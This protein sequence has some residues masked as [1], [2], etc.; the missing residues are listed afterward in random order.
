MPTRPIFE[1]GRRR[2]GKQPSQA[3]VL[4][5]RGIG[6]VCQEGNLDNV[7]DP[8]RVRVRGPQQRQKFLV[9]AGVGEGHSTMEVG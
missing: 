9:R 4:I 8:S 2:T 1:E 5:C 6:T 3:P 7:G